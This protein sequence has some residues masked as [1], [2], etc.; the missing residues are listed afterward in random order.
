M[1]IKSGRKIFTTRLLILALIFTVCCGIFRSPVR[2]E[3]AEAPAAKNGKQQ[4]IGED[5]L[6]IYWQTRDT[7]HPLTSF[8]QTGRAVSSLLCRSLFKNDAN[9]IIQPDLVESWQIEGQNLLLTLRQDIR[10]S[11]NAAITAQDCVHSLLVG[12][13]NFK[14][15]VKQNGDL[16][17]DPVRDYSPTAAGYGSDNQ[18]QPAIGSSY[19]PTA[20]GSPIVSATDWAMAKAIDHINVIEAVDDH[21]LRIACNTDP[22]DVFIS[23]FIPIVPVDMADSY[24]LT[25]LQAGGRYQLVDFTEGQ[26]TLRANDANYSVQNIHLIP[27]ENADAA[28]RMLLENKLDVV[29]PDIDQAIYLHNNASIRQLAYEYDRYYYLVPEQPLETDQFDYLMNFFRTAHKVVVFNNPYFNLPITS[30]DP[31]NIEL[32]QFPNANYQNLSLNI[33]IS[34]DND[35]ISRQILQRLADSSSSQLSITTSVNGIS[36]NKFGGIGTDTSDRLII[37]QT[38]EASEQQ[39][40]TLFFTLKFVDIHYPYE[41][42]TDYA[43]ITNDSV[44]DDLLPF[45]RLYELPQRRNESI[46]D[47]SAYRNYLQDLNNQRDFISIGIVKQSVLLGDRFETMFT[48]IKFSEYNQIESCRLKIME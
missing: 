8:D 23:L 1:Q 42:V 13:M 16:K 19:I 29:L 14:S 26:G 4:D 35:Y 18:Q 20:S 37:D 47:S 36:L 44:R 22:S 32:S 5:T 17:N 12:Q 31:L 10:F 25:S 2:A 46:T 38:K 3:N 6:R 27:A 7:Y 33:A 34:G 30:N 15:W 39:V 9:N 21:K 40:P 24:S 43:Q 48:P 11:D 45:V 28:V 41:P